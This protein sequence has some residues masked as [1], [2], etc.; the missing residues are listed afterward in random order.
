MSDEPD[1]RIIPAG[2][3]PLSAAI[4]W[5]AEGTA[6]VDW[7]TRFYLGANYWP[8]KTPQQ[9]AAA[10]RD[11]LEG[12]D[13]RHREFPYLTRIA[14]RMAR[15]RSIIGPD[16]HL[17]SVL[18]LA[19]P[20]QRAPAA[21]AFAEE[22]IRSLDGKEVQYEALWRASETLRRA[23]AKGELPA[24][25]FEGEAPERQ[26]P[27]DPDDLD[28]IRKPRARIPPEVCAAPVTV[29]RTGILPYARGDDADGGFEYLWSEVL[30]DGEDLL[31]FR[32]AS[33]APSAPYVP[34]RPPYDDEPDE[35]ERSRRGRKPTYD[36]EPF[37]QVLKAKVR[38]SC[39]GLTDK[40]LTD[41]M[42]AWVGENMPA[43][44]DDKT[45]R[46]E[47]RKLVPR[48]LLADK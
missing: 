33:G 34:R 9:I 30:I 22:L 4:A 23:I 36:W 43:G 31:R 2:W 26:H 44:P 39:G 21:R 13:G 48:G 40:S 10:L 37:K 41:D 11:L 35:S 5:V 45:I 14:D 20:H 19:C 15:S 8:L 17:W 42:W 29:G 16:E 1:L 7:N 12:N 18:N 24:F 47:F 25:G 38:E 28:P 3:V 32:E 46:T 6:M 27:Y